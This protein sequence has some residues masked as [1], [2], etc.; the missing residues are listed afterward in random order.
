MDSNEYT[1][2]LF[3]INYARFT[4]Y[5]PLA[6]FLFKKLV[7]EQLTKMLAIPKMIIILSF[8]HLILSGENT[9]FYF[10]DLKLWS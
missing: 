8:I 4:T 10:N 9:L 3:S 1:T 2:T 5:T 6:Y 7:V